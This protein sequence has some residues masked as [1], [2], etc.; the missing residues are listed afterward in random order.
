M[1]GPSRE[2]DKLCNQI[3]SN[4]FDILPLTKSKG[5]L[6]LKVFYFTVGEIHTTIFW[7]FFRKRYVNFA[8]SKMRLDS[9]ERFDAFTFYNEIFTNS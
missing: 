2:I 4:E 3:C 8:I 1:D 9:N 7:S 6:K 5:R